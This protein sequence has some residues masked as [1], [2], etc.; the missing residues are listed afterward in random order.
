MP[1]PPTLVHRAGRSLAETE[2]RPTLYDLERREDAESVDSL[3]KSDQV[4][5]VHDTIE[6]QLRE[7]IASRDPV[8]TWPREELDRRIRSHLGGRSLETWGTWV[9]F[10]WSARLVH[11]LPRDEY[12]EV[13]TDRNRYKI[14]RA[15]QHRLGSFRIGIIGLSVGNMAAVTLAL[16][17]IGGSYKIAD[18]DRLSLSNLNR[19]RAGVHEIGV[20]KTVLAAREMFEIDPYLDIV[21]YADGVQPENIDDFLVGGGRLD[22]LVE[23]CDDL[24]VKVVVRERARAHRIAVIMD[25]SD[26]GLLDIERFDRE[27][28]R[29]ILHGLIGSVKADELRGLET[30]D[31]VP[32]FLAIVDENQMGTRMAAS[33]PEIKH[34]ISTWPQLASAVALGGAVTADAARRILLGE[35]TESG[36][37][38]VDPGTL[39]AD[40]RAL[41]REGALPPRAFE[42]AEEALGPP[43]LPPEPPKSG[44]IDSDVVRWLVALGT[45]APSAHNAQP[46]QFVFRGGELQC[47]HDPAHD[48]P[49][50]D[51]EH[52]ATW[53]AFGALTENVDLA[54]RHLGLSARVRLFPDPSDPGL[55]VSMSFDGCR[56]ETS[57]LFP[58]I[59]TRVTNRKR[60]S[61]G[62]LSDECLRAL[63]LA[64]DQGGANLQLVLRPDAMDDLGNLIGACDRIC[65]LNREIHH[66]A[67]HGYRWTREEVEEH[68]DGLDVATMEFTPSDRAGLR[69]FQQW[70]VPQCLGEIG[71]GRA[72][73]DLAIKAVRGASAIGLI[74]TG[75]IEPESYFRAGRA[76]QRVWLTAASQGL[77]LHPMT[78]LPYLFARL[79]RGGG[80]G[81][82][83]HERHELSSLRE[84]YRRQFDTK[85]DRAEA[86][87]FRLALAEPPTAR[88]LRRR[89]DDVLAFD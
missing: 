4:K 18:H 50:L 35:H 33:L 89:L 78:G 38:Y 61:R 71:G 30:K 53:V 81:L 79:E 28:D 1:A 32:F 54:A 45:L 17:G 56:P 59:T 83:D 26:R 82:S 75:G 58:F 34:T 2:W 47:R 87:L 74:T 36:R 40:G 19:L 55:V 76:V 27:P 48:L 11:I 67:M 84:R 66:D 41:L 49:S 80:A 31:K 62:E 51:F 64:C 57:P 9:Y 63:H 37:Y 24:Y 29:P 44:A 8:Q 16:E 10:P 43:P 3:L 88:S 69:L 7:L 60:G 25:T 22:L 70:R 20:D 68:R 39:V 12:R 52:G 14:T 85:L 72:L 65:L 73:E 6:E 77:A 23:E 46:W 21:R 13:R 5:F 15:E 42:I 86:F